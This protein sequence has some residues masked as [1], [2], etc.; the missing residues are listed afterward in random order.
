MSDFNHDKVFG[1]GAEF[2]TATALC[3]AAEKMKAY[4]YEHWEAHS[5]FPLNGLGELL[6]QSPSRVS[7]ASLVGGIAG[8][9]LSFA[10]I[11]YTAAIDYPLIV[12]GKPYFSF[13]LAFPII[14]EGTILGAALATLFALFFLARLPKLYHPV[15]NW[16]H[17]KRVTGSGFF[18]VLEARDPLYSERKSAAFLESLG[19]IHI[20]VIRE[21]D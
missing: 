9:L 12:Q 4:G 10:L 13:E 6:K 7:D 8:A 15:F 5:P 1:L 21:N 16:D 14:F 17:F 2:T 11:Y 3:Q 18:L 19:G 20:T